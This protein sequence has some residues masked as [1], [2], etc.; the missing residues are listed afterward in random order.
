MSFILT[1]LEVQT[2]V[3]GSI[4]KKGWAVT[5]VSIDSR[6]IKKGE[7]FV[8]IKSQRDGHEFLQSAICNGAAAAIVTRIPFNVPKDFPCIVVNDSIKALHAIARFTRERFKGK[9]VAVTGSVGKTS[10]KS[11]LTEVLSKFGKTHCSPKSFNN[12]LGVPLTL[13]NIPLNTQYVICEIG[14]NSAGEIEPLS[15]MTAPDVA[16]ITN[17]S[18]AH[19]AAFG[20]LAAIAREKSMICSGLVES[21][22]LI[23]PSETPFSE[24][25][26]DMGKK[27][28]VRHLTFGSN[29]L[30]DIY[31][32]KVSFQDNRTSVYATIKHVKSLNF[33]LGA[34]GYHHASNCLTV[35]GIIVDFNLNMDLSLIHI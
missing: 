8:A 24:I 23:S 14:M 6:T 5:G 18:S 10:T 12:Y 35:L 22:L 33:E 30:A 19:L 9:L 16:I 7:L 28:K 13:A 15:K 4:T 11:L 20:D 21:G 34:L 17:I 27:K 32:K 3:G 29:C 1:D 25:V 2:S 31:I 26:I